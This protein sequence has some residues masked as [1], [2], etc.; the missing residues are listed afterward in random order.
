MT[1]SASIKPIGSRYGKREKTK[2][3]LFILI[4]IS[5]GGYLGKWIALWLD[6]SL[7]P[8]LHALFSAPW[9]SEMVHFSRVTAAALL[10]ESTAYLIVRHIGKLKNKHRWRSS[11]P[12]SPNR[13][14]TGAAVA[15]PVVLLLSP[16]NL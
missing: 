14:T 1:K 15:A 13:K 4:L 11:F 9:H 6:Y 16:G 2:R 3:I 7:N 10:A 12:I 5:I 8:S